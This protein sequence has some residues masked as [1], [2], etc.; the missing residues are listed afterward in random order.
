MR[1]IVIMEN[2]CAWFVM[3]NRIFR[4][5]SRMSPRRDGPL[6]VSE[7]V[8]GPSLHKH[9]HCYRSARFGI[10]EGVVMLVFLVEIVT[11]G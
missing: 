1:F 7:T 10:G 6:S 3:S 11:A 9:L 5:K 8:S 4:Y 2:L